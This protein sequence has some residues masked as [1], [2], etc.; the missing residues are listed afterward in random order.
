MIDL[1]GFWASGMVTYAHTEDEGIYFDPDGTGFITWSNPFVVTFDT[2]T[3]SLEKGLLSLAGGKRLV[4]YHDALSDERPSEVILKNVAVKRVKC[5]SL[6]D[7]EVEALVF[8]DNSSIFPNQ[9]LGFICTDIR[10]L[11]HYTDY[12]EYLTDKHK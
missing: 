10:G 1:I 9:V 6:D 5:H 11:E 2:F 12:L 7:D 3:W 8:P 4:F